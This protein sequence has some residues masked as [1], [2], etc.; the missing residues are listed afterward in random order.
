MQWCEV[1][2]EV[3][4]EEKNEI[5][6]GWVYMI[7]K[8]REVEGWGERRAWVQYVWGK[9]HKKQETITYTVLS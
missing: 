9:K 5:L 8:W 2:R 3:G 7:S 6:K 1:K 4:E